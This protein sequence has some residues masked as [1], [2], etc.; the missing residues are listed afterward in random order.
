MKLSFYFLDGRESQLAGQATMQAALHKVISDHALD[1]TVPSQ[2]SGGGYH[3]S[4]GEV[5]EPLFN[6]FFNGTSL[7]R[8]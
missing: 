2:R 4:G 5:T 1:S 3:Q 6:M 8:C 7:Q